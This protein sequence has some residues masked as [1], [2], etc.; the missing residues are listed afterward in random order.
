MQNFVDYKNKYIKY[1]KKYTELKKMAGGALTGAGIMLL[2]PGSD[3]G[4]DFIIVVRNNHTNKF[5]LPGGTLKSGDVGL[6]A[7]QELREETAG[8]FKIKK[9]F[10]DKLNSHNHTTIHGNYKCYGIQLL[11]P[12]TQGHHISFQSYYDN[13]NKLKKSHGVPHDYLETD[14]IGVISMTDFK[15]ALLKDTGGDLNI[16]IYVWNSSIRNYQQ[17]NS[18][19][20]GRDKAI[21]R[22]FISEN[23]I[24][25]IKSYPISLNYNPS[26][27][28]TSVSYLKG[29]TTYWIE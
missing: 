25:S 10:L 29:L 15:S 20:A 16:N 17:V 23:K 22:N 8:L 28:F 27:T 21:I 2:I 5:E 26:D 12:T 4:N 24:D 1:K 3:S 7:E 14:A 9:S 18:V 13:L 19:L 6:T 11:N